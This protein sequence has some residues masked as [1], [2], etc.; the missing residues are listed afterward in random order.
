MFPITTIRKNITP[1]ERKAFT[2][3]HEGMTRAELSIA[4]F[5]LKYT[6][7]LVDFY[8]D[9]ADIRFRTTDY[10]YTEM[11][12]LPYSRFKMWVDAEDRAFITIDHPEEG[13]LLIPLNGNDVPS[14]IYDNALRLIRAG[15]ARSQSREP[16]ATRRLIF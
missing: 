16:M 5:Y 11:R 6:S 14:G 13:S 12:R 7:L 15:A 1:A 3:E 8:A 4:R 9:Y 2:R 10:R